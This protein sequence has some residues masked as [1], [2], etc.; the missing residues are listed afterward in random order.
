MAVTGEAAARN[1][2]ADAGPRVEVI[3]VSEA[4][5]V[6]TVSLI[7]EAHPY[8]EAILYAKVSGYLR[9]IGVDKGD[10]VTAGEVLGHIESP[11]TDHQY[12]AAV[13]DAK[14]KRINADRAKALVARD[15]ISHQD[16]DQAEADAEVAEANVAELATLR[17]YEILKA[18]FDG[19]VTARYADPGAL[20]QSAANSQTSALPLVT[21]SET[22]RLRVYVYPAQADAAFIRVGDPVVVT[23]P[24][25]P[26]LK[27]T[28]RITRLSGELDPKTRTMLT[29]IDF[30]NPRGEILPGSFVEVSIKVR[31]GTAGAIEIPSRAL[32]MRG[33]K[34]FV[35][36]LTSDNRVSFRPVVLA[37]D[38][39]INAW[40]ISGLKRGERLA[41]NLSSGVS[42][43]GKVQPVEAPAP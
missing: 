30:E 5:A 18:P 22:G 9:D 7:G 38:D 2:Q 37:E 16:A 11:E 33:S 34:P 40:V 21:V 13:A 20:L 15:M 14:N 29:E 19:T 39:G 8:Q 41:V 10:Q 4:G 3:R 1:Q 12:Q 27:V 32:V 17:S 31:S 42:D 36:V 6:H 23:T 35:A 28:A 26:E 24:E 25:R 43:G